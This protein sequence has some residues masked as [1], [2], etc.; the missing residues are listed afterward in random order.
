MFEIQNNLGKPRKSVFLSGPATKKGGGARG[1]P[2]RKKDL[3]FYK[4]FVKIRF[5]LFKDEKE[6]KKVPMA[7]KSL[8][9]A[10]KEDDLIY[11]QYISEYTGYPLLCAL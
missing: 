11:T 10:I 8:V 6:R 2:L 7:T 1:V 4:F 3:F 9:H 5:R